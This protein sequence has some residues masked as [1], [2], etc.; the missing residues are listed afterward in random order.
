MSQ[1]KKKKK[2][3]RLNP[4]ATKSVTSLI[5]IRSKD[6]D[7][8]ETLDSIYEL[9]KSTLSLKS[10][11]SL[12]NSNKSKIKSKRRKKDRQRKKTSARKVLLQ[13]EED[14]KMR[15]KQQDVQQQPQP[16]LQKVERKLPRLM[17]IENPLLLASK[18]S[19]EPP[20]TL[21]DDHSFAFTPSEISLYLNDEKDLVERL[22]KKNAGLD[23]K[24]LN[25]KMPS[26][27]RK[28]SD[29]FDQ[30]T[31]SSDSSINE[32]ESLIFQNEIDQAEQE[33]SSQRDVTQE[34]E[35]KDSLEQQRAA[36]KDEDEKNRRGFSTVSKEITARY[37][38]LIMDPSIF[39]KA[40]VA[41]TATQQA[42]DARQSANQFMASATQSVSSSNSD[43]NILFP[44]EQFD[45]AVVLYSYKTKSKKDK[46]KKKKKKKA[47]PIR[48]GL[49]G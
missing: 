15:E 24:T 6:D 40:A 45:N 49:I 19:T 26:F 14:A 32:L 9:P 2:K 12:P 41:D 36:D 22:Q 7:E 11:S 23:F 39:E 3:K 8:D 27:R 25:L 10:L 29:S 4:L 34:D 18:R 43:Q 16:Q 28:E 33:R 31:T 48:I 13:L 38:N 17:M 42:S 1:Q 35:I 46:K 44:K 37:E 20:P 5:S 21:P 47:L 30:S